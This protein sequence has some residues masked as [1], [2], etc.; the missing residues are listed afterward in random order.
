MIEMP[1]PRLLISAVTI[2]LAVTSCGYRAALHASYI[3]EVTDSTHYAGVRPEYQQL[4]ALME[5]D[6]GMAPTQGNT[7]QLVPDGRQKLQLMLQDMR[8]ASSSLYLEY[9]RIC[10]DSAGTVVL[11]LLKEKALSGLDVRAVTDY[12][13]VIPSYRR[14]LNELNA[15]GGLYKTFYKPVWFLDYLVPAGGTHR[16]HRKILMIDGRTAYVGGRNIQDK[17]YVN[18]RDADLRI[19]GPAVEHIAQVYMENFSLSIPSSFSASASASP[20]PSGKTVQ[21]I[22]DSP[23]DKLLPTRNCFEW[24]I[25]HARRYFYLY[26]PYTPPPRSTIEALKEA[27]RRGVD[28]RWILPGKSD[29]FIEKHMAEALY[30][31]LLEA[32][33]RLYEWQ[34]GILHTKQFMSDD[35]LLAVGS[36]NMDNLSFFLNY[37]IEALVYDEELTCEAVDLYLSDLSSRCRE[38]TLAE[39]RRWGLLR[40]FRNWFVYTFGGGIG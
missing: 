23:T 1:T 40:R 5:K 36:A 13:A 6:T 18:W 30:R 28:V 8:L 9:Y 22:P 2:A 27:A 10:V 4:A 35:Y 39:V 29:V 33:V 32:G 34:D 38:V 19:T 37:E 24:A 31:E 25:A 16:D 20:H 15:V 11:D 17:Y 12:A 14:K 26:C 3:P 21:I 7:L